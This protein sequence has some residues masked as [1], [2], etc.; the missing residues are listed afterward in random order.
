MNNGKISAGV[1]SKATNSFTYVL[2]STCYSKRNI[3]IYSK[4]SP[5]DYKG[6]ATMMKNIIKDR[7]K[8][9]NI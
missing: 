5:C 1:F 3:K 4:I 6:F 7:K 2:P 9:K 8:V